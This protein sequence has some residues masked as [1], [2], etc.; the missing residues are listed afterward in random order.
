MIE[1]PRYCNQ[2]LKI[3]LVFRFEKALTKKWDYPG[4][5]KLN[6][7]SINKCFLVEICPVN[8]FFSP[9]MARQSGTAALKD[10]GISYD[11]VEAVVASYCYGE[12]TSGERSKISWD[13]ARRRTPG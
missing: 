11:Q 10:A 1:N 9:D 6:C 4:G 7:V 13:R 8:P 2:V 12:P 3:T 5:C